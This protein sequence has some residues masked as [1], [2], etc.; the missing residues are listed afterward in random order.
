MRVAGWYQHASALSRPAIASAMHGT[1][2]AIRG[3]ASLNPA[4]RFAFLLIAISLRARGSSCR[5]RASF[6]ATY[7]SMAKPPPLISI[8]SVGVAGADA[9]PNNR[10]GCGAHVV[11]NA[12]EPQSSPSESACGGAGVLNFLTLD[13][14]DPRI[15]VLKSFVSR[16]SRSSIGRPNQATPSRHRSRGRS[17]SRAAS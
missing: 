5:K 8:P 9:S 2:F 1:A 17:F 3:G 13:L 10:T 7:A 6:I 4:S 14:G 12:R 16:T 15:S 11:D